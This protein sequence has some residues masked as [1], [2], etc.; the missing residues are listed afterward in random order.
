MFADN[1][2]MMVASQSVSNL[3]NL[4]N[5]SIQSLVNWLQLNKLRLNVLKTE[6]ENYRE[7]LKFLFKVNPSIDL[8]M[9]NGICS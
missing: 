1:T 2:G 5:N 3:Q 7:T 8:L 4:V 6:S 9:L